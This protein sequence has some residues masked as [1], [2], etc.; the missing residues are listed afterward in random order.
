MLSLSICVPSFSSGFPPFG[1]KVITGS[2]Q[3]SSHVISALALTGDGRHFGR[4]GTTEA[5]AARASPFP[6]GGGPDDIDEVARRGP[7]DACGARA[8]ARRAP[9]KGG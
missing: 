4:R 8:D 2:M 6:D 7:N 3:S 9:A 1:K 5:P